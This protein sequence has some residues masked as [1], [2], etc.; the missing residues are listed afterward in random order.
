MISR[1]TTFPLSG[2]IVKVLPF[3]ES[4]D[5]KEWSTFRSFRINRDLLEVDTLEE[6]YVLGIFSFRVFYQKIRDINT[7]LNLKLMFLFNIDGKLRL[8]KLV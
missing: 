2:L 4:Q 5:E 8:R 1:T 7:T 6:K 3:S